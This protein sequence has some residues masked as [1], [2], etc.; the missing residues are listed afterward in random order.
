MWTGVDAVRL[1]VD[2][3]LHRDGHRHGCV[4]RGSFH[5]A[6]LAR[7]RSPAAC[8]ARR[9][10]TSSIARRYSRP[11]RTSEIGLAWPINSRSAAV[12]ASAEALT[13]ATTPRESVTRNGRGPTAPYAKRVSPEASTRQHRLMVAR[14]T[15]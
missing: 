11:P 10:I 3:Q 1:S 8:N 7:S 6:H 13:S 14:S 5:L 15:P 4:P 12:F 9:L 2:D